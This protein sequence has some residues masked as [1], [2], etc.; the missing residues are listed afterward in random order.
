MINVIQCIT[1]HITQMYDNLLTIIVVQQNNGKQ[2]KVF[3]NSYYLL[4]IWG[5]WKIM[6]SSKYGHSL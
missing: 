5:Q 2:I 1:C 4:P 3:T 6:R